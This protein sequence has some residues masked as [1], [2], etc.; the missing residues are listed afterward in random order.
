MEKKDYEIEKSAPLD[1]EDSLEFC[2]DIYKYYEVK[3]ENIENYDINRHSILYQNPKTIE[4]VKKEKEEKKIIIQKDSFLSQLIFFSVSIILA[5]F[6][7]RIISGGMIQ[8]TR[9]DGS[10]MSPTLIH[11]ERLVLNKFS[12]KNKPYERFDIVVFSFNNGENFVKRVIGLPGEKVNIIDGKIYINDKLLV[13]DP[14]KEKIDYAG[15]A[16]KGVIVGNNQYFVIGDNRNRSYDSR[17][18][19]IGSINKKVIYGKVWFRFYPFSKIGFV[20]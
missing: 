5:V 7:S 20:E 1:L 16:E 3:K 11:N 8:E 17:Y 9:V 12:N 15:I 4:V 19:E 14:I 18:E 13:D 6:L 10:S 2:A